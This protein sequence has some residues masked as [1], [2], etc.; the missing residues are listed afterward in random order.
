MAA[1]ALYCL[2]RLARL[3]ELI[4]RLEVQLSECR[5]EL[6]GCGAEEPDAARLRERA[7]LAEGRLALLDGQRRA[8]LAG[9]N[10]SASLGVG[11][12]PARAEGGG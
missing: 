8:I 11:A 3:D 4:V 5:M 12:R 2:G 9:L 6:E 7:R 1:A 10:G